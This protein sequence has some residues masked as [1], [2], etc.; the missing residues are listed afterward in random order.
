M[1]SVMISPF[2]TPGFWLSRTPCSMTA[3]IL[4][5]FWMRDVEVNLS[6]YT[7]LI[8]LPVLVYV[9]LAV[10]MSS[11]DA[12]IPECLAMVPGAAFWTL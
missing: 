8:V 1:V 12:G 7:I 11:V 4:N 3:C 2:S 5:L 10:S 9:L 6:L